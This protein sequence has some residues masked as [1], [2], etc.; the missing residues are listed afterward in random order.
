MWI[1][2]Q[3]EVSFR[4]LS[5]VHTELGLCLEKEVGEWRWIQGGLPAAE[6]QAQEVMV[7][8]VLAEQGRSTQERVKAGELLGI[9][10]L[11]H[12]GKDSRKV[13]SV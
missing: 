1:A 7:I 9:F 4:V 12:Q 3:A 5:Q 8:K 10:Y 13:V 6:R 11:V 2:G